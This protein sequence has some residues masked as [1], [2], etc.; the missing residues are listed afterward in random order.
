MNQSTSSATVANVP[1]PALGILIK[2]NSDGSKEFKW[3][4][5]V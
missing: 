3:T 1:G 5:G 4:K 2:K